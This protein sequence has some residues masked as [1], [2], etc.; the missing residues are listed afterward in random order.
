M[1]TLDATMVR[2]YLSEGDHELEP[3]L[4]CLHDELKVGGVTVTRGLVGFGH[5][6]R[7]HTASLI[8]LSLD[9]PLVLEFFEEPHKVEEALRRLNEFVEP[10]HVVTWPVKVEMDG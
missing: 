9:L 6:G 5:S 1:T 2:V 10:G 7:F 4:R 8:D 3:L